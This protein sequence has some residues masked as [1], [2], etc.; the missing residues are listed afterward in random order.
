MVMVISQRSRSPGQKTLFPRFSDFELTD[1]KPHGLWC[2]IMTSCDGQR[3]VQQHISGFFFR[4]K[5][6][7]FV[8]I[9]FISL[10][11]YFLCCIDRLQQNISLKNPPSDESSDHSLK[12]GVRAI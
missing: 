1:T 12:S 9:F 5:I 2:D 7:P 11:L 3:E 10:F 6:K 4:L 8:K